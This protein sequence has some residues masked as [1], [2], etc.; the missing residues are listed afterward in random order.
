MPPAYSGSQFGAAHPGQVIS[1]PATF[2]NDGRE[3]VTR[4]SLSLTG[5]SG[6]DT[7]SPLSARIL[8]TGRELDGTLQITV[9]P[10]TAAGNYTLTAT[11]SY[12]WGFHRTGSDSSQ[13]VIQVAVPPADTPTL[14]QL[15]WLSAVNGFGAIG[16]NE[17]HYGGPLSI[18]Q[19]VYPHGLWVNSVATLY[20][21]L[22]GN[23]TTFSAD[24]GLDDSDKHG[25]ERWTTSS[26][27]TG[28]WSMTVAWSPT[29]RPRSTPA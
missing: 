10:G 12:R 11:A 2:T 1:V 29:P 17:N 7:S 21:Y 14:D 15:S 20:Y 27:P 6:W 26:T 3:P 23:C 16:I 8:P 9:P 13:A 22:G 19:V 5:P 18:H 4:A 25:R 28:S 24:L